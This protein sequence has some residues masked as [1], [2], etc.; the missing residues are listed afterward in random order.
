M[1]RTRV[2]DLYATAPLGRPSCKA[3]KIGD[4]ISHQDDGKGCT[5][6]AAKVE[7]A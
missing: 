5:A 6:I 2:D 7:R 3:H 4:L 1:D